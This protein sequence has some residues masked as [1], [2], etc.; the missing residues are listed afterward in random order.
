MAKV[1]FTLRSLNPGQP[2]T[3][4]AGSDHPSVYSSVL[5]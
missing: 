4:D 3:G 5:A 1:L 2:L